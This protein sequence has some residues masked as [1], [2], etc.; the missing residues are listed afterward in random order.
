MPFSASG[1]IRT[2]DSCCCWAVSLAELT[3]S[4]AVISI[5][6]HV[7]LAEFRGEPMAR[8]LYPAMI[9]CRPF[10][11]WASPSVR[12]T[13]TIPSSPARR[14]IAA[15]TC[16]C[17]PSLRLNCSGRRGE[18]N[19]PRFAPG[20]AGCSSPTPLERWC[21]P[22]AGEARGRSPRLAQRPCSPRDDIAA[23]SPKCYVSLPPWP[24]HRRERGELDTGRSRPD[25]RNGHQ[26]GRTIRHATALLAARPPLYCQEGGHR[27]V[28]A[29]GHRPMSTPVLIP[30]RIC[31]FTDACIEPRT[32]DVPRPTQSPIAYRVSLFT[33][34]LSL[35][36]CT[37][38]RRRQ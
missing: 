7:A 1:R 3:T 11:S 36:S 23:A 33:L 6:L 32:H 34:R 8:A 18:G 15:R 17:C 19:H 28:R 31:T 30:A 22:W 21:H 10:I 16:A 14:S 5:P 35:R 9:P 29:C 26:V 25:S 38:L 24:L 37:D 20:R 12:F 13:R 2:A 4:D 27:G